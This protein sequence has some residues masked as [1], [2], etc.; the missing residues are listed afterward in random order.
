MA[1]LFG[2]NDEE[3]ENEEEEEENEGADEAQG[4]TEEK[5]SVCSMKRGDYMI[6]VYV[7][8][9][10]NLDVPEG[11]VVDPI[12]EINCLNERKFTTALD[13]INNTGLAIWNEHI[14]FEP[15]NVEVERL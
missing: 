10:K 13:D 5:K 3:K 11:E 9:A 1:S 7:E 14:F 6:H 4:K 12:V 8:Q 15:K 2:N